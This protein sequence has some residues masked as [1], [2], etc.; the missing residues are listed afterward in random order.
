[1][2]AF[3]PATAHGCRAGHRHAEAADLG[4]RCRL[5]EDLW[6]LA[7]TTFWVQHAA[8]VGAAHRRSSVDEFG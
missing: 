8:V 2:G 3:P 6:G 4:S 5:V 1:M 7:A